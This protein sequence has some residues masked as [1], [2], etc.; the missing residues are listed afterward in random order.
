MIVKISDTLYL[1]TDHITTI[2]LVGKQSETN[3]RGFVVTM[4]TGLCQTITETAGNYLLELL[5]MNESMMTA[6]EIADIRPA[7]LDTRIAQ[8]L[9][10]QL[11]GAKRE[12]IASLIHEDDLNKVEAALQ[13]LVDENVLVWVDGI[14]YHKTNSP[15]SSPAPVFYSKVNRLRFRLGMVA[16]RHK[17]VIVLI[18]FRIAVLF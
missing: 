3:Q 12:Q 1:N 5:E 14:F 8:L 9:R 11:Y 15:I 4:V 10:D 16:H 18:N 2:Q 17:A 7:N 6:E 13:I